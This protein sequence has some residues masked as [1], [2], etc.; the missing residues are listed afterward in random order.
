LT[1]GRQES[2]Q[3]LTELFPLAESGPVSAVADVRFS[4]GGRDV[5]LP[6]AAAFGPPGQFRIDLLDPLDRPVSMIFHDRGRIIQYRPAARTAAAVS[7]LPDECGSVDAGAWAAYV[8]G[9]GPPPE[10]RSEFRPGWAG[11]RELLRYE[12]AAPAERITYDDNGEASLRKVE[13]YCDGDRVMFLELHA[14]AHPAGAGRFSVTFP[15]AGLGMALDI[16]DML[17]L[18]NT[19]SDFFS[20]SLPPETRWVRWRL[21]GESP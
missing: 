13:W 18:E 5:S 7:L 2:P 4:Y 15:H 8:S 11:R 1:G 12:M 10:R 17:P 20:P 21:V 3:V 14:A 16:K 19:P 6:A 9:Q